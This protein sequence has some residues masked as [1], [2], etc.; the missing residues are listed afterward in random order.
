MTIHD[1]IFLLRTA[2]NAIECGVFIVRKFVH[3]SD[4]RSYRIILW[5]LDNGNKITTNPISEKEL[6][7]TN[8]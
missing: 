6:Q 1:A 8:I 2:D 5:D 4:S 3:K 7:I